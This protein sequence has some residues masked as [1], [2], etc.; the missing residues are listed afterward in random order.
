MLKE[1]VAVIGF[2]GFLIG[3]IIAGKTQDEVK[4]GR[5]YL[6]IAKRSIL[7]ISALLILNYIQVYFWFI[8]AGMMIGYFLRKGMAYYG[9]A[10]GGAAIP[11]L[12][13]WLG[14]FTFLFA[15][16]EGTIERKEEGNLKRLLMAF[17]LFVGTYIAFRILNMEVLLN[18]AAGAMLVEAFRKK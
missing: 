10:L 2:I 1:L 9:A 3:I 12:V 15:L 18:A 7:I 8:L 6:K 16:V 13:N 17:V 5:K 11:A 4:P 14:A